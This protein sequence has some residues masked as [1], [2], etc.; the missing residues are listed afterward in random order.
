MNLIGEDSPNGLYLLDY[1][2]L[3]LRNASGTPV[4]QAARQ[5]VLAEARQTLRDLQ[6]EGIDPVDQRSLRCYRTVREI[7][8]Y[9]EN[10]SYI[11][12]NT[13][14]DPSAGRGASS[15]TPF[16]EDRWWARPSRMPARR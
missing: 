9:M 13:N 14:A 10:S 6:H 15:S 16:Q 3:E 11:D 2:P 7:E 1:D 12:G 5:R 4:V 8:H